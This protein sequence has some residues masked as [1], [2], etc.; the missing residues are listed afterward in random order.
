MVRKLF[1]PLHNE[2]GQLEIQGQTTTRE[3]KKNWEGRG[4]GTI[5]Q[6]REREGAPKEFKIEVSTSSSKVPPL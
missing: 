3:E 5:G 2:G 6:G 4:A 1:R